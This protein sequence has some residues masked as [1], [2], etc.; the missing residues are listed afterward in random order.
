MYICIYIY[1]NI[2]QNC[3]VHRSP[4]ASL[5]IAWHRPSGPLGWVISKAGGTTPR[6]CVAVKFP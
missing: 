1:I 6:G 5:A 3:A 2:I 4:I